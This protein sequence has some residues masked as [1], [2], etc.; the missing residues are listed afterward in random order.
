MLATIFV[1]QMILGISV[2]LMVTLNVQLLVCPEL[3]FARQVTRFVPLLKVEPLGGV[4][5]NVT[6]GQLSAAVV[7]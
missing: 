6:P 4:Q 3:S 5:T 2:S 7:V 1:E